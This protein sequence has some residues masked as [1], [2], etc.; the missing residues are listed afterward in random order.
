MVGL[1]IGYDVK[2]VRRIASF[3][4][5]FISE[6]DK[7]MFSIKKYFTGKV[8]KK[9]HTKQKQLKTPTQRQSLKYDLQLKSEHVYPARSLTITLKYLLP[10]SIQAFNPVFFIIARFVKR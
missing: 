3:P 4:F 5:L 7:C 9:T 10:V 1:T 6:Y 8:F 2:Y